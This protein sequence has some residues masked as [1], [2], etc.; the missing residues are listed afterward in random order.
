MDKIED[1]LSRVVKMLSIR[2]HKDKEKVPF[3]Q[4]GILGME[5]FLHYGTISYPRKKYCITFPI[6]Y[7]I[8]S[9]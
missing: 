9:C 7:V 3:F 6:A 2:S 4:R 5:F 1:N 8:A